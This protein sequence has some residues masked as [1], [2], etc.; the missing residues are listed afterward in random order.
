MTKKVINAPHKYRRN[1]IGLMD[2]IFVILLTLFAL[3]III[4]CYCAICLSM[5]D[6]GEYYRKRFVFWPDNVT[7]KSYE[8]L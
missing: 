3:A 6:E 1:R 7:W 5:T 8:R 2:L 4:Q